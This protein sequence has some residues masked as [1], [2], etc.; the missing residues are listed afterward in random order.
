ML[1]I[2][3]E[4]IPSTNIHFKEVVY[5]RRIAHIGIQ[6]YLT[7]RPYILNYFAFLNLRI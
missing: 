1:E 6:V 5:E 3:H 2:F 7:L 4:K